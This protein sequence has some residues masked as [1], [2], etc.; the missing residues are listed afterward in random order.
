MSGSDGFSEFG[1]GSGDESVGKKAARFKGKAGETY[2]VSFPWTK[3]DEKTGEVVTRFVGCDRH[4]LAGVGYFLAKG[5]E[6]TKLAGPSKQA[7]ATII[8]VWP[9]DKNG[10]LNG[11]AIAKGEGIEVASWVF[12]AERY[13]QLRRRN[14][15]FPLHE[16]DLTMACTDTQ[17]QKMDLSPCK[18]STFADLSKKDS[19]RAKEIISAIRAQI[20]EIEKGIKNELA[21]DMTLDKI[22]EKMGGTASSAGGGGAAVEDVDQVLNNILDD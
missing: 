15:E 7:V 3:T 4:Y 21:R 5:P 10:K 11:E 13:D 2:R 12:S 18:N 19:A 22:R 14:N 1:F 17:Y 20:A 8:V 9:T 6:F 16:F